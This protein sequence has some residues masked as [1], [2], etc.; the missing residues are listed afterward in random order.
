MEGVPSIVTDEI[1]IAL[2]DESERDRRQVLRLDLDT[3]AVLA[4]TLNAYLM[5]AKLPRTQRYVPLEALTRLNGLR[6]VRRLLAT[7][8]DPAGGF[9]A[10]ALDDLC[11]DCVD[12]MKTGDDGLCDACREKRPVKDGAR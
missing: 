10:D 4:D 7:T 12:E 1:V 6:G 9:A 3:A 11:L 2:R 8:A 5:A